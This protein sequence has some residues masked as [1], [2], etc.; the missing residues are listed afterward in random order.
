LCRMIFLMAVMHAI[1]P[2]QSP[3]TWGARFRSRA[4]FV[5][6]IF[7]WVVAVGV[8]LGVLFRYSAAPGEAASPPAQWPI[9]SKLRRSTTLPTLV[10]LVHPHC[11]C[12]RASLGELAAIMT[13]A[14]GQVTAHVLFVKP[15]GVA[16]DWEQ[17]DLWRRASSIDGVNVTSDNAASEAAL[18]G[19]K[20]SGQTVVY[21]AG[22]RLLFSG[23]ITAARGHAG[24]NVGRS[25][26]LASVIGGPVATSATPVF[27]CPLADERT[28]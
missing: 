13:R 1:D 9:E 2:F 19:A 23:G 10:M 26:A 20:T 3:S 6:C 7:L 14:R 25:N 21:D 16:A 17:T 12:S 18:F 27:G 15:A 28:P 11:P 5:T 8:G 22:G 4:M 24:D